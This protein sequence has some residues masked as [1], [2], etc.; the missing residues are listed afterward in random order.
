MKLGGLPGQHGV[1]PHR[2]RDSDDFWDAGLDFDWVG[3][4]ASP[5]FPWASSWLE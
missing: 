5:S 3:K 1:E 4:V 2:L